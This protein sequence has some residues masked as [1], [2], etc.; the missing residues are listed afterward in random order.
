MG[1]IPKT[2][3]LTLNISILATASVFSLV[4]AYMCVL[5]GESIT[6]RSARRISCPSYTMVCSLR[7]T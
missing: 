7:V 4:T 5:A 2:S 3:K 1:L 6:S